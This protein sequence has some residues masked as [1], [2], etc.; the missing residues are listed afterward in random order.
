MVA[1]FVF[2][3][4]YVLR[5]LSGRV[6]LALDS[7]IPAKPDALCVYRGGAT[8]AKFVNCQRNSVHE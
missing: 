3:L 4:L 2:A 7:S 1:A 6:A 5:L 8:E